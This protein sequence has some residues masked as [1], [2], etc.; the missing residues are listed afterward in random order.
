MQH[1]K[2]RL[3]ALALIVLSLGLI[4]F[5]WQQL[6]NEGRYYMKLAAFAPLVGV[7]GIYLLLFPSMGG[8]PNTTREKIV[9]MIVF[10]IG[11]AAGLFNWYMMDP[12]FFGG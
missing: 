2:A 6:L 9:A 3:F 10:A 12:A 8:K 7:G 5:N 11:L 4:Y 1:L